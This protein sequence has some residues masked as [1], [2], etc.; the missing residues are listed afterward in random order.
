M[1]EFTAVVAE[2]DENGQEAEGQGRH[3][4]EVHGDDLPSMRGQKG[5]PSRRGPRRRPAH[6][7]G[8]GQLGDVVSEQGEFRVN[9]PAAPG[10]ILTSHPTDQMANLRVELWTAERL[11]SGLPSPVELEAAAVPG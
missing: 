10:R 6:V 7:L 1:E 11:G 3:E 2:H 4:E 8:D 9:A 5:A